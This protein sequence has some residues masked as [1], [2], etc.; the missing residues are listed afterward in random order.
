MNLAESLGATS[1]NPIG[2]IAEPPINK[3]ETVETMEEEAAPSQPLGLNAQ[4]IHSLLPGVRNDF[5]P[6]VAASL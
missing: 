3:R 5:G 6:S 1:E 2:D 4:G